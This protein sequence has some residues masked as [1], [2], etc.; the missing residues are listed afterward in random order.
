MGKYQVHQWRC[1]KHSNNHETTQQVQRPND[2]KEQQ[3][4]TEVPGDYL[5]RSP[6]RL[7][8]ADITKMEG[9]RYSKH[10]DENRRDAR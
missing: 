4:A 9:C 8:D 2:Q 10:E 3:H 6:D 1:H 5:S 7:S